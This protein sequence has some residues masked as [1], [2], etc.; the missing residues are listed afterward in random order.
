MAFLNWNQ[1]ETLEIAA[2]TWPQIFNGNMQQIDELII[3]RDTFANRGAAGTAG[4]LFYSENTNELFYD[5]GGT[6]IL[7]AD[8]GATPALPT[9]VEGAGPF[10]TASPTYP[11]GTFIGTTFPADG[12][13]LVTFSAFGYGSTNGAQSEYAFRYAGVIDTLTERSHGA[14][15]GNKRSA[16]H[17]QKLFTGVLFGQAIGVQA[18]STAT[19]TV[20]NANLILQRV[21]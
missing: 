13:F 14:N 19:F 16:L 9:Q 2:I 5:D 7:I 18:K 12:N 4:R 15:A 8:G 11:A 3:R 1:L 21:G 17:T 10:V 20:E 6:W